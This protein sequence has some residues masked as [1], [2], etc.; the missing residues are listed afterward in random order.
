M[1]SP[2]IKLITFCIAISI[3]TTTT[4]ETYAEVKFNENRDE[5][6]GEDN[7]SVF[8]LPTT[9][10]NIIPFWKCINGKL[11]VGILHSFAAGDSNGKVKIQYKFDDN[12]PSGD[13]SHPLNR[14]HTTTFLDSKNAEKF[15]KE[16]LVSKNLLLRVTDPYNNDQ[17]TAKFSLDGIRVEFFKQTCVDGYR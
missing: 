4:K 1:S 13:V 8:S 14:G 12:K 15:T 9:G 5:F 17:Q 16:A 6:T 11:H 7:S 2:K 3:M 10:D